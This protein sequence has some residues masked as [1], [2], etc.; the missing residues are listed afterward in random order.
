MRLRVNHSKPQTWGEECAET[1]AVLA[2]ARES[3]AHLQGWTRAQWN[4]EAGK[5]A[6]RAVAEYGR[7]R[8]FAMLHNASSAIYTFRADSTIDDD[9]LDAVEWAYD[10]LTTFDQRSEAMLLADAGSLAL[11]PEGEPC[12]ERS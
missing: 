3:C 2:E 4:A 5:L 12:N 6:A 8:A 7:E 1:V 9:L 10:L 11:K